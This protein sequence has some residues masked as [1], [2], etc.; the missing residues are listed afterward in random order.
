MK[1]PQWRKAAFWVAPLLLASCAT[2]VAGRAESALR[3][4]MPRVIGP[5]DH[6]EATVRGAS[7]DASHF[8]KVHVVGNRVQRPHTPVI[9]RFEVDLQDV[10]FDLPSK[11]VSGIGSAR[12]AVYVKAVDLTAYLEQQR[13]IA[14]PSVQLLP[15][16]RLEVSG[17]FKVLGV[18]LA[19]G[20]PATFKGRLVTSGS[21]L[22]VAVDSL[23]LGD[24]EAPG[25]LKGL[26][27][28]AVNPLFDLAAYAVPSTVERVRVQDDA[29]LL[30]ASGSQLQTVRPVK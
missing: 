5:A 25:L 21:Q 22:R 1:L 3:G 6:Y 27:A 7:A 24:R 23:S 20:A 4:A 16:D 8:D 12:A 13:W 18:D 26:V 14:R 10:T 19:A 2:Y 9:D 30:E 17:F 11:Q 29:I 15:P 28:T